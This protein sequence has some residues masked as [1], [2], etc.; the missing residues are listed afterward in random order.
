MAAL[1]RHTIVDGWLRLFLGWLQ[2]S[3]VAMS[4]G[5]LA[6]VGLHFVTWGFVIAATAVTILSR[7]IYRG[8]PK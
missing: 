6:V 3:L 1:T 8:R 2:M 4:V 7:L 5:S